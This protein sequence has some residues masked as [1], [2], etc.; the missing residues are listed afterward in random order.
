MLTNDKAAIPNQ[1]QDKVASINN[2]QVPKNKNT[3]KAAGQNRSNNQNTQ[4]KRNPGTG[5][6][7]KTKTQTKP[8]AVALQQPTP[9]S[10]DNNPQAKKDF[11]N[12]K[13]CK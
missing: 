4:G 12:R 8:N 10:S 7:N 9:Y 11:L 3:G 2:K 1:K 6:Q 13:Q 5:A